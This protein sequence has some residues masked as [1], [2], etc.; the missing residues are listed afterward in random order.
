[1]Q[2]VKARIIKEPQQLRT[3]KKLWRMELCI[4]QAGT[5]T[6][7]HSSFFCLSFFFFPSNF[8]LVFELRHVLFPLLLI[9]LL[10]EDYCKNR[11]LR[12]KTKLLFQKEP[13][14]PA[15]AVLIDYIVH[16]FCA[17]RRKKK[18]MRKIVHYLAFAKGQMGKWSML[19]KSSLRS[20]LQHSSQEFLYMYKLSFFTEYRSTVRMIQLVFYA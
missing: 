5:L 2:L 1:M 13:S 9:G 20:R 16:S 4:C 17:Q 8:G 6:N 18:H 10:M 12:G 15:T 11:D 19:W 7:H 3:I 14:Y